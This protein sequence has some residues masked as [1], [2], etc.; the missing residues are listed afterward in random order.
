VSKDLFGRYVPRSSWVHDLDPRVKIGGA[1]AL[2]LVVLR[3]GFFTCAA[4]SF[5]LWVLVWRSRIPLR[6]VISA[7]MPARF[8]LALLFLLHLL[9]TEGTPIPLLEYGLLTVTHEGLLEGLL[10]S[11][12]FG[13]LLWAGALLAMTASPGGLVDGL[14]WMLRPLRF[15]GL[16]SQ[17]MAIMVSL[18]LRLVPTLIDEMERIRDAQAARGAS[19]RG[20]LMKRARRAA[21]LLLPV[22][23]GSLRRGDE[24]AAAMEARGYCGGPRTG[25]R[26]L[27][28]K[29]RDCKAAA[30]GFLVLAGMAWVDVLLRAA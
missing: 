5:F 27:R 11:W 9:F 28:L 25:L 3:G 29:G 7:L 1:A 21:S 26:E 13:V 2:S 12:R 18:A 24:L 6:D 22:A 10:V 19:F 4:G 15:L 30:L 23:L 17:D 14:E 16:R 20:G 8:F